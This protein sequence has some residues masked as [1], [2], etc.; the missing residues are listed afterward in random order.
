[1]K[2]AVIH[3]TT[4]GDQVLTESNFEWICSLYSFWFR[5]NNKTGQLITYHMP[6]AAEIVAAFQDRDALL[7][8]NK[9]LGETL[10]S[11]VARNSEGEWSTVHEA[12]TRIS[13]EVSNI[14]NKLL[15]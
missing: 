12:D 13:E 9:T 15:S 10:W 1:M 2:F 5:T 14:L 4:A 11:L 8:D 7:R 6:S 3:R